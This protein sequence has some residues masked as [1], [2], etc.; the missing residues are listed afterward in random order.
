MENERNSERLRPLRTISSSNNLQGYEETRSVVIIFITCLK[1]RLAIRFSRAAV[2]YINT[3][4]FTTN[5]ILNAKAILLPSP[6]ITTKDTDSEKQRFSC[7]NYPYTSS[8]YSAT[9]RKVM[10]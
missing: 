5:S 2:I 7:Q 3:T 1:K 4:V 6:F 9:L 8:G 10:S